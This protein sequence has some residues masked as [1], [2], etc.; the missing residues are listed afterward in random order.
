[1]QHLGQRPGIGKS[2]KTGCVVCWVSSVKSCEAWLEKC[3]PKMTL[4]V[5]QLLF[6]R[7]E[8]V[9]PTC[10]FPFLAHNLRGGRRRR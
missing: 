5:S 3:S 2:P 1:M 4:R 10:S 8:Y 6:T 9:V 7:D